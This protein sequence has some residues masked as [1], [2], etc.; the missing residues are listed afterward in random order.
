MALDARRSEL[1]YSNYLAWLRKLRA[2]LHEGDSGALRAIELELGVL[3]DHERRVLSMAVHDVAGR[4][5]RRAKTH[6]VRA[7]LAAESP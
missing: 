3:G 6:F 1:L 4:L 2:A 5:P 7:L